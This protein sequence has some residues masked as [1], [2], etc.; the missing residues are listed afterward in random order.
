MDGDDLA[1]LEEADLRG[2]AMHLDHAPAGGI[3]HAVQIAAER[4]HA[5]AGDAP[6]EL[7]HRLERPGR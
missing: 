4:D 5:V 1:V 2:R 7:Q 3:G 6:L